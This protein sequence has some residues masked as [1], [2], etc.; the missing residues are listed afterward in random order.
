[1]QQTTP[2]IIL[3]I[4]F[5]SDNKLEYKKCIKDSLEAKRL[6]NQ[7]SNLALD[8]ELMDLGYT[9]EKIIQIKILY[10]HSRLSLAQPKESK[11]AKETRPNSKSDVIN[12]FQKLLC[13]NKYT[14]D[15]S[16]NIISLLDKYNLFN[17]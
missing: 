1:M 4:G 3:K 10:K 14:L 11:Q 12:V 16:N 15:K 17:L 9:T 2:Q 13:H 5:Q 7:H 8:K 6:R